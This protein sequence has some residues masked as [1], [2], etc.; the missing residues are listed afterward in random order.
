MHAC[1]HPQG[2]LWWVHYGWVVGC[3]INTEAICPGNA[4]R[5]LLLTQGFLNQVS[6]WG[7]APWSKL[8]TL[9]ASV[10]SSGKWR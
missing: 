7:C 3:E 2:T 6:Y 4:S 9:C 5:S 1:S 8:P 10:F